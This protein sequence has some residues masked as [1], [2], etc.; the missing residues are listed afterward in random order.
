MILMIMNYMSK[1]NRWTIFLLILIMLL[2]TFNENNNT[3]TLAPD[4]SVTIDE[5]HLLLV[6]L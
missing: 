2:S 4:D 5:R 1:C 3:G 6:Q